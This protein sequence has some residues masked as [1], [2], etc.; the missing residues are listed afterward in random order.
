MIIEAGY[1]ILTA[2]LSTARA[3]PASSTI[4]GFVRTGNELTLKLCG[5]RHQSIILL[6]LR[7]ENHRDT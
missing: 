7:N 6:T 5:G 2:D 4:E 3:R 1:D